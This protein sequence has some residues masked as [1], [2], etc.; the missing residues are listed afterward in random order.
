MS[1]RDT[2]RYTKLRSVRVPNELWNEAAEKAH[3]EDM[4]LAEVIRAMLADYV[5]GRYRP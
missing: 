4:T 5:D 2:S 3:G 1:Q